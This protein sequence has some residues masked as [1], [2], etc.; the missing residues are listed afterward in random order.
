MVG[1][2]CALDRLAS[3]L[4]DP[5]PCVHQMAEHAMWSIWFRLGTEEAN[6]HLMRGSMDLEKRDFAAASQHFCRAIELD[7]D[8]AE[9]YNQRAI[10][11][12]L[13]E[14]FEDSIRDCKRTIR[15]MPCHFGAWAGMGHCYAHLDNVSEA[16]RC[17]SQAL[18]INPGLEGIR[19]ALRELRCSS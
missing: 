5:D 8:F 15:R 10:A 4:S 7:P 19:E 18:A 9:P 3:A 12:Y 16:I 13:Q 14:H 2:K 11:H 6:C 17:Y 1:K